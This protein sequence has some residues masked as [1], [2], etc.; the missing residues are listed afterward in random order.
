MKSLKSKIILLI[1]PSA[2]GKSVLKNE[3]IKQHQSYELIDDLD[4]LLEYFKLERLVIEAYN[5]QKLKKD[6]E[7]FQEYS[8]FL[9]DLTEDYL[10]EL[11]DG[12]KFPKAKYCRKINDQAME[13]I[14]PLVWDELIVRLLKN[15]DPNKKYIVEF[16]RG[17]DQAFMQCFNLDAN[18]IYTHT[19]KNLINKVK[20]DN[21]SIL[22]ITSSF[23]NRLKRND[24]RAKLTGQCVPKEVMDSVFKEEI[25]FP[26][27]N[28]SEDKNV[29]TGSLKISQYQI[30]VI[31]INN[32]KELKEDELKKYLNESISKIK[33]YLEL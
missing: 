2:A 7:N 23:N 3:F 32:D 15:I 13:V 25:F 4:V 1:G 27:Y 24:S 30:P 11:K 5:H 9:K 33:K 12:V 31:T 17:H 14:N 29:R 22:H 20:V 19:I 18:K 8:V 6:L 28:V 16:A 21:L 10:Q 26:K